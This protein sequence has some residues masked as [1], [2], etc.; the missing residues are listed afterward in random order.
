MYPV[1]CFKVRLTDLRLSFPF[2]YLVSCFLMSSSSWS[3]EVLCLLRS[4]FSVWT[5][6]SFSLVCVSIWMVVVFFFFN[7]CNSSLR[8]SIFSLSV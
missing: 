7:L 5:K 2:F 3:F 6:P 8:S 4:S 1:C